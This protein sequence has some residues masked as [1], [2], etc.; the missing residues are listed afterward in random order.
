MEV[1]I[2][3]VEVGIGFSAEGNSFI[4]KG[5]TSANLKVKLVLKPKE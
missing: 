1:E 2:A 5:S 4:A 3:E